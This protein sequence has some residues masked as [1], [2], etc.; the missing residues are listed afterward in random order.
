MNEDIIIEM[1]SKYSKKELLTCLEYLQSK[2][3][4]TDDSEQMRLFGEDE[5]FIIQA[6]E[7]IERYR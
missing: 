6:I 4:E 3:Q 2:E 1:L 7:D 5:D